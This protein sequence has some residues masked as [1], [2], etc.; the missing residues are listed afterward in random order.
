MIF[1]VSEA[2]KE[3]TRLQGELT[4]TKAA[5]QKAEQANSD[6]A[7][8]IEELGKQHTA[9]VAAKEAEITALKGERDT[10]KA[11]AQAKATEIEQLKAGQKTAEQI[12]A[13]KAAGI[14]A[15]VGQ[16]AAVEG[17]PG[18][19]KTREQL[20][21]EYHALPIGEKRNAFYTANKAAMRE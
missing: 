16:K 8:E 19:T 11:D 13:E 14:A 18:D 12:G 10:L 7:A 6:H 20:W 21:Q 2:N 1:K 5:L 17:K 3:I 9:A 4:T 15:G